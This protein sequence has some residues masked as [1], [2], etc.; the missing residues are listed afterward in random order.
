MNGF[1][2]PFWFVGRVGTE[3]SQ[4][5]SDPPYFFFYIKFREG[6]LLLWSQHYLLTTSSWGHLAKRKLKQL[7]QNKLMSRLSVSNISQSTAHVALDHVARFHREGTG[8]TVVKWTLL[9]HTHTSKKHV[10]FIHTFE[11]RLRNISFLQPLLKACGS[12][13]FQ[14][15]CQNRLFRHGCESWSSR[16]K[17]PWSFLYSLTSQLLWNTPQPCVICGCLQPGHKNLHIITLDGSVLVDT[18]IPKL[19]LVLKDPLCSMVSCEVDTINTLIG[20]ARTRCIRTGLSDWLS[21]WKSAKSFGSTSAK[22]LCLEHSAI[23][24]RVSKGVAMPMQQKIGRLACSPCTHP[25]CRYNLHCDI[26]SFEWR[27]PAGRLRSSLP[28]PWWK[29]CFVQ[30]IKSALRECSVSRTNL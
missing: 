20:S 2:L 4:L 13:R 29:H 8:T 21:W 30:S 5:R 26:F 27:P 9:S 18:S 19:W 25:A 16:L 23:A 3:N 1:D 17:R 7:V 24:S 15:P 14:K 6:G 12:V 11:A 28:T 22:K 10:C